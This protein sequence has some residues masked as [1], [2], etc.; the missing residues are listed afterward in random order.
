[1]P[2]HKHGR[3][4]RRFG[5]A[6]PPREATVPAYYHAAAV[7]WGHRQAWSGKGDKECAIARRSC[8]VSVV[9][10]L[11][12]DPCMPRIGKELTDLMDVTRFAAR[13]LLLDIPPMPRALIGAGLASQVGVEARA[14]GMRRALVVSTGL[15]GTGVV[16]EIAGLLREADVEP[17]VYDRVESNPKDTNVMEI[18]GLFAG[19]RCDG[20]VSVGGGS[21]H[22]ATKGARFVGAH[23]GRAVNE[24][25]QAPQPQR[26]PTAPQIAINTTAG[27]GSETTKMAVLTDTTSDDAPVKWVIRSDAVV[28]NLAINDP[29]LYMTMP[30]DLTAFCGFDVIAH[31][32]ETYFSPR[33]NPHSRSLGGEAIRLVAQHLREAVA[34]PTNYEA[35][36]GMMWAQ[37]LAAM[38]FMSGSLG[39]VHGISHAVSA[40]YDTHHGLNCGII[41]PHAWADAAAA[42]PR[43]LADLAALMGEETDGLSAPQAADRA[44]AAMVRLLQDVEAPQ[45]FAAVGPYTKSRMGEG[46]YAAWGGHAIKG[47]EADI[48]RVV[49]HVVEVGPTLNSAHPM[50]PERVRR[51]VT[52]SMRGE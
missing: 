13:D 1:M 16:E 27:T 38:A 51:L 11:K 40:F 7:G 17:V 21:A 28:P 25:R 35:R 26:A 15:R 8:G 10:V 30:P 2:M 46:A 29:L 19:E 43:L 18:Y 44:V 14:M 42:S 48:E 23:D 41:L 33:A 12:S 22:D 5:A 3:P 31:A 49:K 37:Y 4:G 45:T 20:Y 36:V 47:D 39:I 9:A 50:T 52:A 32:S 6:S 24:F 34:Y